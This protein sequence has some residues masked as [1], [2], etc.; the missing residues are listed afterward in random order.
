[1]TMCVF[2]CVPLRE[3]ERKLVLQITLFP[4]T[5]HDYGSVKV[6]RPIPLTGTNQEKTNTILTCLKTPQYKDFG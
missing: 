5:Y 1:M 3:R 2:V 6:L 4:V